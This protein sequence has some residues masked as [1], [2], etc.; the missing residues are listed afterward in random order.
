[1]TKIHA[2]F[3]AQTALRDGSSVYRKPRGATANVTRMS[4]EK[5][6]RGSFPDDEKYLGEVIPEEDG[7]CIRGN[8]PVPGITD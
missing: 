8:W 6:S 1:M 7:G 5:D 4:P 2:W 3:S